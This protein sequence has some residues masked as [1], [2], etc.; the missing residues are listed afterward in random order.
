MKRNIVSIIRLGLVATGLFLVTS[1][2]SPVT[3]FAAFKDPGFLARP[4]GMGG[5]YA[6][7]ADDINSVW[8][9]PAGMTNVYE[10]SFLFTYSKPFLDLSGVDMNMS[11]ATYVMPVRN[12]GSFGITYAQFNTVDLYQENTI[13]LSYAYD[14]KFMSAGLSLKSLGRAVTLDIRTIDDPVFAKG[15]TKSAFSA[16]LGLYRRWSDQ[17]TTGLCV[18]DLAQP[19]VGFEAVDQVP[20]EIRAGVGTTFK[21]ELPADELLVSM[22]I[23]MRNKDTN[24][25]LGGEMWFNDYTLATRL[26]ANKNEFALGFS[27]IFEIGR[28]DISRD[29]GFAL[30]THYSFSLPYYVE[31]TSG[32]HRISLGVQF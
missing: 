18:K 13:M 9:N 12:I 32:S 10:K 26:G 11:F 17:V 15:S 24:V 3:V 25:Y 6:G 21:M 23:G 27:Y 14:M 5:A 1:H 20:M 22:D 31:G 28:S 4:M 7:V 2:Q 16:D 19:D 8:Y 30:E 29:A